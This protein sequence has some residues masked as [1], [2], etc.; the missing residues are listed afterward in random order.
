MAILLLPPVLVLGTTALWI[1]IHRVHFGIA[2]L[3][4]TDAP[5]ERALLNALYAIRPEQVIRFAPVTRQTMELACRHS[6]TLDKYR[7]R[8]V[9]PAGEYYR[10]A[11]QNLGLSGEVGTWLNW[12]LIMAFGGVYTQSVREMSLAAQEIRQALDDGRL[13]RRRALYPIDPA[14]RQWLRDVPAEFCRSAGFSLKPRLH[15]PMRPDPLRREDVSAV[16]EGMFDDGLLRR[17]GT[18]GRPD[19]RLSGYCLERTSQFQFV[20][21][22]TS[23]S[24]VLGTAPVEP[25][26]ARGIKFNL[27]V[28]DT[29]LRPRDT[30]SVEFLPGAAPAPGTPYVVPLS[31]Q[32]THLTVSHLATDNPDAP[33]AEKWTTLGSVTPPLRGWRARWQ[34]AISVY[35][36]GGLGVVVAGSFC[37]GLRRRLSPRI[38]RRIA[39]LLFIG[40]GLLLGRSLFYAIVAAWL[41]WALP[42]YSAPNN[43][44]LVVW[45]VLSAFAFGAWF[46]KRIGPIRPFTRDPAGTL[47]QS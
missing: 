4:K 47:A 27:T 5:Q 3:S 12:H 15:L 18:R 31:A 29:D 7:S 10:I 6:A 45:L 44:L 1:Q 39:A 13:P 35:Y 20:R 21:V 24:H 14:W 34:H 28:L 11:E 17:Q 8:L 46:M 42:R 22:L 37:L 33:E 40:W 25:G 36:L 19:L 2:A 43:I 9:D 30:V 26:G 16:D 23:S 32:W 38:A 41:R